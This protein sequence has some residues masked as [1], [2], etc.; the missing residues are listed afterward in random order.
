MHGVPNP[1]R[2][3]SLGSSSKKTTK[4]HATQ[5][6]LPMTVATS[7]PSVSD[8]GNVLILEILNRFVPEVMMTMANMRV[9]PGSGQ[10]VAPQPS[11][12]TGISGSIGLSGKVHGVVY[13]A[14]TEE[15]AGLVAEQILGGPSSE[16]DVSDVVA[17]LTNMITGNLKSQLCDRGFNCALSIPS[18]VCGEHITVAAKS[19]TISVRNNYL[20][21]VC[22][23]PLVLHVFAVL[24]T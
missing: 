20:F 17:E 6:F 9:V 3:Q 4:H 19:A 1:Q 10:I 5:T 21:D 16:Q 15:L 2:Q 13:T 12:L 24:E 7:T 11:K 18:V 14:F 23:D 22:K 8:S